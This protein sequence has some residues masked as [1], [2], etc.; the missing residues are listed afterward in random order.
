MADAFGARAD[1]PERTDFGPNSEAFAREGTAV[2]DAVVAAKGARRIA[3]CLPCRNE[4]PTVGHVVAALREGVEGPDPLIDDLVVVDDG[5][6]D[7]SAAVALAAGARVV[8]MGDV[9]HK[10]GPGR[11]KGNVLW[12]SLLVTDSE[13]VVWL[14]S[15]VT[16]AARDWV[17]R[18]VEPIVVDERVS[19]VKA[20]YARPSDQGGGGRT[21]ELVVRPLISLFAPHLSWIHQPLA[22]EM[23]VRRSMIE[24]IP[25]VQG[26]GVEIAMI[27]DLDR[28]FGSGAITEVFLGE[29]RHNHRDLESLRVQAAEVAG[30]LLARVGAVAA[31]A[32]SSSLLLP[33]GESELLNVEERPPIATLSVESEST[34]D[35]E[36]TG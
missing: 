23:A 20:A 17:A 33:N 12:G 21:T 36:P 13:I 25:L 19:L 15:D 1:T 8:S 31:E 7:D 14:D 6:T 10:F 5:S 4:S 28:S 29:R 26:W 22:G 35:L 30:T 18:L 24:Q 16:T 32:N 34:A 2:I 3:V 11:G 27:V 9:H